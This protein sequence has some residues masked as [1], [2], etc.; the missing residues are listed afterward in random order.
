MHTRTERYTDPPSQ[1][2]TWMWK[3]STQKLSRVIGWKRVRWNHPTAHTID[4]TQSRW[5]ATDAQ[6]IS[7]TKIKMPNYPP[8]QWQLEDTRNGTFD[9]SWHTPSRAWMWSVAQRA[10]NFASIWCGWHRWRSHVSW[11]KT[12]G[13]RW[14]SWLMTRENWMQEEKNGLQQIKC[15]CTDVCLFSRL[16]QEQEGDRDTEMVKQIASRR[17][18]QSHHEMDRCS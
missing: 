11:R 12:A 5:L 1:P 14:S 17:P 3:Y 4:C 15:G 16:N 6:I 8:N 10:H 18:A 13:L 7:L 2:D 9:A